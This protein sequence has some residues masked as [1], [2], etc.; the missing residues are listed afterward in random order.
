MR[1]ERFLNARSRIMGVDVASLDAQ[2]E[3]KRAAAAKLVEDDRTE[4]MRQME[5]DRLI[6]ESNREEKEM[7]DYLHADIK[8]DWDRAKAHKASQEEKDDFDITKCGVSAAQNF[9]GADPFRKE[10]IKSQKEQMRSWVF[11]QMAEKQMLKNNKESSEKAY[12]DMMVA[13]EEIRDAADRE[14]KEMEKFLNDSVKKENEALVKIHHQNEADYRAWMREKSATSIDL[15]D[16]QDLSMDENGRIV[17]KDQFR[18]YNEAQIRRILQEN[19]DLRAYN[20]EM[21][22]A[23]A[24]D[25]GEWATQQLIQQQAM[26]LAN[27]N[28][29]ELRKMEA[30]RNLAVIKEQMAAQRQ[31]SEFNKKDKFGSVEE[32]FFNK[33]GADCR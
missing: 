15:K 26:E 3:A 25:E 10:R 17:R 11:E 29:Q 33:F 23:H 7:K 22:A 28:E 14:E 12:A 4:R 5:I 31:R 18:G 8:A 13:V 30:M 27:H 24:S 20:R 19:E 2:V 6:E 9:A 32:G 21:V 16:N 1:R